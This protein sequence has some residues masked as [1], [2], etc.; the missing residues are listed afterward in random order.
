MNSLPLPGPRLLAST[1]LPCR[2]IQAAHNRQPE[3]EA[4]ISAV[5]SA[6]GLLE[7]VENSGHQMLGDADPVITHVRRHQPRRG[8]GTLRYARLRSCTWRHWPRGGQALAQAYLVRHHVDASRWL[9]QR[10]RVLAEVEQRLCDVEGVLHARCRDRQGSTA[11]NFSFVVRARSN[12]SASPES[13]ASRR[14]RQ[15]LSDQSVT[16]RPL[17]ELRVRRR[18]RRQ[19]RSA[20]S[21]SLIRFPTVRLTQRW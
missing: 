1:E 15:G 7:H 3:T 8:R 11:V 21:R 16:A 13:A 10:D 19:R 17:G 4:T 20:T 2:S 12:R 6:R 9:R 18:A 14:G 5:R